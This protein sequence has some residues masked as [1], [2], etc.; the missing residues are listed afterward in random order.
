MKD[1][2]SHSPNRRSRD[3]GGEI[4]KLKKDTGEIGETPK[5]CF[6]YL[7]VEH[8]PYFQGNERNRKNKLVV[9]K[10]DPDSLIAAHNVA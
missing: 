2:D 3:G 9:M 8:L 4:D 7:S 1:L 6:M 5:S 10:W